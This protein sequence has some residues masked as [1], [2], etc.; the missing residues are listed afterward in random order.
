MNNYLPL[1]PEGD[2]TTKFTDSELVGLLEWSLPPS[3]RTKFDLDNYIP[4]MY[5]KTRLIE[6]CEAIERNL[7][8]DDDDENK[9][10]NANKKAKNAKSASGAPKSEHKKNNGF[11]C[12]RCGRNPHH[13]TDKCRH[14][15]REQAAPS[16]PDSKKP[17]SKRTFRKEANA[18]ARKAAKK[19]SLKILQ[20]SLEREQGR[21]KKVAKKAPARSDTDSDSDADSDKSI[22]FVIPRK[23]AKVS[24]RKTEP[25]RKNASIRHVECPFADDTPAEKA[26]L[27]QTLKAARQKELAAKNLKKAAEK[28]AE[29][30]AF[31]EATAELERM[32]VD[33]KSTETSDPMEDE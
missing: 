6:E 20:K 11:W 29:E 9:A 7:G 27:L 2:E 3:W 24:S 8:Q 14:L 1:F 19:G 25:P 26:E 22:N 30:A 21:E 15:N 17:F 16:K 5:S 32:E 4:T 31:L 33:E 23:S 12:K 18:I 28:R 10:K 13:N